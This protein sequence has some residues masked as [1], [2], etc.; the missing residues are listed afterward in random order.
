M[1]CT[2]NKLSSEVV[3]SKYESFLLLIGI[4]GLIITLGGLTYNLFQGSIDDE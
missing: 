2:I 3:M 4:F 1:P